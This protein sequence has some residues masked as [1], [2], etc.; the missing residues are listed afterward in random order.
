[1][2]PLFLAVSRCKHEAL[3]LLLAYEACPNIQD[4]LGNTPLHLAVAK[5]QPCYQCS[6]LLLKHHAISLVFNNT[7]QSPLSILNKISDK[8]Q[9]N[10]N[11]KPTTP[12]GA[13]ESQKEEHKTENCLDDNSNGS[14][15]NY[16][17]HF[18]HRVLIGDIFDKLSRANDKDEPLKCSTPNNSVVSNNNTSAMPQKQLKRFVFSLID[19]SQFYSSNC[20]GIF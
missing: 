14:N 17:F 10:G 12:I 11:K 13:S 16:T 7:L 9:A 6:Y 1:M 4:N 8:L 3:E 18:I 5:R 15:W 2:P 20:N 19:N